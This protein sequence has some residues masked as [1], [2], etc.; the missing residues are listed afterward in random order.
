[1]LDRP[2]IHSALTR[3]YQ[4][5]ASCIAA[6]SRTRVIVWFSGLRLARAMARRTLVSGDASLQWMRLFWLAGGGR[7]AW[8]RRGRSGCRRHRIGR[9]SGG[10]ADEDA[11]ESIAGSRATPPPTRTHACLFEPKFGTLTRE[12]SGRGSSGP[13]MGYES[14][15]SE[16]KCSAAFRRN[17]TQESVHAAQ[18]LLVRFSPTVPDT[19]NRPGLP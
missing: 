19:P 7:R 5:W 14:H 10:E 16:P 8:C 9:R 4:D 6:A 15:K 1:M 11:G 2:V 17:A 3:R 18:G 13:L 12:R